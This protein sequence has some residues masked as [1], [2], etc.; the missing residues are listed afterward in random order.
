MDTDIYIYI[1]ISWIL[2]IFQNINKLQPRTNSPRSGGKRQILSV[3]AWLTERRE[4]SIY[5]L[6]LHP[7][8]PRLFFCLASCFLSTK[9]RASIPHSMASDNNLQDCLHPLWLSQEWRA[10]ASYGGI[11]IT[12][13]YKL[14]PQTASTICSNAGAI[15]MSV[16][17]YALARDWFTKGIDVMPDNPTTHYNLAITLTSKLNEHEE[18]LYHLEKAANLGYDAI[19]VKHLKGILQD[20]GE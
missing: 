6:Q 19:K 1:Y 7:T 11:Q 5:A 12:P 15:A 16:G 13:D 8:S 2:S 20:L 4:I 9:S 3:L 14:N 18:A 10:R 17:D